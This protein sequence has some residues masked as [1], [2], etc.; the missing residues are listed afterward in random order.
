MFSADQGSA[1]NPSSVFNG[2]YFYACD[3]AHT[4]L[5]EDVD[6]INEYV[7]YLTGDAPL[8]HNSVLTVSPCALGSPIA[9]VDASPMSGAAPLTVAFDGSKSTDG[10]PITSYSW[11]FGDG[12]SASGK[13]LTHAYTKPG[14][15][16]ATLTISDDAG[17]HASKYVTIT[18]S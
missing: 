1:S 6:V 8:A 3:V 4:A 2:G 5:L 12:T 15:F 11:N 7:P 14:A 16:N 17:G 9:N 10:K 13:L 18:A